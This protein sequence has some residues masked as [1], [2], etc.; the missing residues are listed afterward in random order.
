M[1]WRRINSS[2]ADSSSDSIA[3]GAPIL[4]RYEGYRAGHA[5]T[6]ALIREM[7]ARP[8]AVALVECDADAA[9]RLPGVGLTRNDARGL[10]A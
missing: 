4:A 10:A 5:L 7:F 1:A 2:R 6:G 9:A 8:G 3:D